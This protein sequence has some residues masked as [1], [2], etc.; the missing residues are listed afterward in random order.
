MNRETAVAIVAGLG[1]FFFIGML[2]VNGGLARKIM[3]QNA[4]IKELEK[5]KEPEKL[6]R[7]RIRVKEQRSE[8]VY[9]SRFS[10]HPDGTFEIADHEGLICAAFGAGKWISAIVESEPTTPATPKPEDPK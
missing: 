2:W 3:R 9:G 5:P 7:I 4:R 10:F 6:S 8:I 1:W